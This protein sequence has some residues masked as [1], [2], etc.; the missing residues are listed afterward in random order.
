MGFEPTTFCLEGRSSTTEL[1]PRSKI[2]AVRVGFEPTEPIFGFAHLANG[3]FRP[4]SHLTI[5]GRGGIRT[6]GGLAPTSVFKT[7][8]INRSTTLPS[9][10]YY[11]IVFV[12]SITISKLSSMFSGSMIRV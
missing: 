7:D 12:L 6:H 9:C 8:A 5:G 3:C 1:H 10:I 4:L 11:V 2:L